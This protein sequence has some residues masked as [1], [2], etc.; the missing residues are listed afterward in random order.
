MQLAQSKNNV[1][2]VVPIYPQI[3]RRETAR[4]QELS[5]RCFLACCPPGYIQSAQDEK[6][7]Y[8]V[9]QCTIMCST[10]KKSPQLKEFL[11]LSKLSSIAKSLYHMYSNTFCKD[12]ASIWAVIMLL[13]IKQ[14]CF[15]TFPS[16]IFLLNQC[17]RCLFP[18]FFKTWVQQDVRLR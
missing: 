12:S 7:V 13:K 16:E 18:R 14:D 9:L 10:L 17:F 6:R 5:C 11:R 15:R 1:I 3:K 8:A 4:L 2:S